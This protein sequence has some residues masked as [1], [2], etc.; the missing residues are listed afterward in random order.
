MQ[1]SKFIVFNVCPVMASFLAVCI[2][3][4]E[5]HENLENLEFREVDLENL[6]EP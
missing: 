2:L 3:D 4:L 5:N 6:E 1:L